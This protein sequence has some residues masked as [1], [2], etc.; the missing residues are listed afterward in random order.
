MKRIAVKT[1]RVEELE[2][3][4]LHCRFAERVGMSRCEVGTSGVNHLGADCCWELGPG[5]I[6]QWMPKIIDGD[7][8]RQFEGRCNCRIAAATIAGDASP[9]IYN[10]SVEVWPFA[11][12][13]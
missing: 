12:R 2:I 6:G 11:D 7:L 13:L 4:D 10:A 3:P 5:C 1:D 8:I 9:L